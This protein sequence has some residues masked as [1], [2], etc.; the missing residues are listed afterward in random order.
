M[1][2]VGV[3]VRWL[4]CTICEWQDV[5]RSRLPRRRPIRWWRWSNRIR[6]NWISPSS[7]R[8]EWHPERMQELSLT[9][10]QGFV[11]WVAVTYL[12]SWDRALNLPAKVSSRPGS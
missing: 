9:S 7:R 1:Q 3:T 8:F 2:V 10:A 4:P 11:P 5:Q 12:A 6:P